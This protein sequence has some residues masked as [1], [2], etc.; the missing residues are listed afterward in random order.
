MTEVSNKTFAEIVTA[1]NHAALVLQKFKL[2]YCCKG[3]RTLET[4]CVENN[5]PLRKYCSNLKNYRMSTGTKI[6]SHLHK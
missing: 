6:L 2:D 3:K 1:N 5:I 4:A